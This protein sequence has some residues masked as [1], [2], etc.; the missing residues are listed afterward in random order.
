MRNVHTYT[1]AQFDDKR[2]IRYAGEY[3]PPGCKYNRV[4]LN[5]TV[6]SAGRQFDRLALMFLDDI[7]IFRT[8]TAE[9]TQN[10]IVWSYIKDMSSYLTVFRQPRKIIFD[11]GNLVDDTYTG[12]WHTTLTATYFTAEDLLEPADI[13]VPVSAHRSPVNRPSHFTVPE[14][15]AVD[16]LTIPRNARKVVFSISACGQAA[17]EF[18]WSNVLSSDTQ[19]FGENNTLYGHSPFRELQLIIDGQLAGVAWP[20]P[21]IF[22]GGV[23]PGFWRPI[24]GIDAF[25]M[26]EDEIDITPFLP[27][28][29]DD[30]E[31]TFEIRVLGIE[32]DGNGHGEITQSIESNWI[33][34]GKLFIWLDSDTSMITGSSPTIHSP[35][36]SISI[37][38]KTT[39]TTDGTVTSHEYSVQVSRLVHISSNLQTS[40]GLEK[41]TWTQDLAYSNYGTLANKGNDQNLRQNTC[42]L[43]ASPTSTYRKVFAY[44]L[45]VA[46][47]YNTPS[48]G[49]LTIDATMRRG[50]NVE[51]F[52][53][54]A[55]HNEWKAVAPRDAPL[56]GSRMTNL[57]NG[58]ASYIS[59]PAQKKSYGSGSTE[60]HYTLSGVRDGP[61]TVVQHDH[62]LYQRDVLAVNGSIL[63]DRE[64]SQGKETGTISHD[65]TQKRVHDSELHDFAVEDI[66]ALLGRGP[67]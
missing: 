8:S 41:V 22:T 16:A 21:V 65:A 53:E 18:W 64:V 34:T 67:H 37:F 12:A 61:E 31:H 10:G 44:P 24:V 5:F 28:L 48:D 39:K 47:S 51:Q 54:L 15:R 6:T 58:T 35:R 26:L 4:T 62:V 63:V 30:K 7:E 46:S 60:Q 13:I 40:R 27:T 45:W 29:V 17:E 2:L 33:V 49:G 43:N 56:R 19:V 23:V 14:S 59:I 57:Q 11:L 66:R 32:D 55:F 25:D 38:S 3:Y 36:P 42:G 20:F 50:K 1:R 9:P 52:G